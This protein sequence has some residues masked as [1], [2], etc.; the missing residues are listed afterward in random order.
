MKMLINANIVRNILV[1]RETNE[2]MCTV[3][4]VHMHKYVNTLASYPRN[5]YTV[6]MMEKLFIIAEYNT[7]NN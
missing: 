2:N 5:N 7:H 1:D 6:Q 4:T 3:S